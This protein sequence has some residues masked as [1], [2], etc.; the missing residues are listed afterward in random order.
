M[1]DLAPAERLLAG[2]DHGLLEGL[3]L[4]GPVG[5]V[6]GE[7]DVRD[8]DA[9]RVG[10][11]VAAQAELARAGAEEAVREAEQHPGAVAGGGVGAG[12]AAVLEVVER[13][14]AEL[15]HVVARVAVEPGNARDPARVMLVGGVV[16]ACRARCA[17]RPVRDRRDG[18]GREVTAA[19]ACGAPQCSADERRDRRFDRVSRRSVGRT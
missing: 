12:G 7:E 11:L 9:A 17:Q 3:L 10:E 16:E 18:H 19:G 14:E 6:A 1:R 4:G 15:D 8:R 13:R 2:G 5:R